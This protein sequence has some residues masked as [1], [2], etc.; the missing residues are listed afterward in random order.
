MA[1]ELTEK[2][3]R[4]IELQRIL[5]EQDPTMVYLGES[6]LDVLTVLKTR[7]AGYNGNASGIMEQVYDMGDMSAFIH[8]SRPVKRMKQILSNNGIFC[9]DKNILDKIIDTLG[10]ALLWLCCRKHIK[11]RGLN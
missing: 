1:L 2:E 8:T 7:G 6:L 4:Q 9:S 5:A 3:I 10:Y 11:S